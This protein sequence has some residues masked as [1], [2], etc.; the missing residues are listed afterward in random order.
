MS[1][2]RGGPDQRSRPGIL[3]PGAGA[4][5]SR[6][7]SAAPRRRPPYC[8]RLLLELDRDVR[9]GGGIRA[10]HCEVRR[11]LTAVMDRV[12]QGAPKGVGAPR[13]AGLPCGG[14]TL[15]RFLEVR[16]TQRFYPLDRLVVNPFVRG[17]YF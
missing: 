9:A 12:D 11:K 6:K 13:I 14:E 5:A 7:R 8:P 10:H 2:K 17:D 3:Y 15:H 4:C 16:I 1:I